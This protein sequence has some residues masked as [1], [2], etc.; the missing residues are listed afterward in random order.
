M[1][2]LTGVRWFLIVVLIC[3]S[4]IISDFEHL[5]ICLLAINLHLAS[6]LS[7]SQRARSGEAIG[8]VRE[9]H[10]AGDW[11]WPPAQPKNQ[12][13]TG[14]ESCLQPYELGSSNFSSWPF[15]WD[16]S[17]SRHLDCNQWERGPEQRTQLNQTQIPDPQKLWDNKSVLSSH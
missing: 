1:A 15:L 7:P 9:A 14:A 17:P 8:C 4:L 2:I 12:G 6:R 5:F 16:P 11:G 13:P 10:V 3:I